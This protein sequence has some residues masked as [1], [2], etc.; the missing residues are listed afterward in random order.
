MP[1]ARSPGS[2]RQRRK[3]AQGQRRKA[4]YRADGRKIVKSS[5]RKLALNETLPKYVRKQS[6]AYWSESRLMELAAPRPTGTSFAQSYRPIINM[7]LGQSVCGIKEHRFDGY[8][9]ITGIS[10]GRKHKIGY[11][12]R[13]VSAYPTH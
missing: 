1:R 5:E 9:F 7:F 6:A 13:A 2:P 10:S 8:A 3:R 4:G 11:W 12:Q